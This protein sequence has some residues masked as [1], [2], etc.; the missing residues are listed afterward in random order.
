MKFKNYTELISFII[1]N[2]FASPFFWIIGYVLLGVYGFIGCLVIFYIS[3]KIWKSSGNH[4]GKLS[5]SPT[6]TFGNKKY[7]F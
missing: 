5:I 6:F 3:Y 4:E 1:M 7:K 2:I